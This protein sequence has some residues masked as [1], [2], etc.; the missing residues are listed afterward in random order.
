MNLWFAVSA[1]SPPLLGSASLHSYKLTVTDS[2]GTAKSVM[3]K[4][5]V[6]PRV[7]GWAIALLA[8]LVT[9]GVVFALLRFL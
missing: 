6:K 1:D 2:E 5:V 3:G 8:T 4:L 7:P 9:A